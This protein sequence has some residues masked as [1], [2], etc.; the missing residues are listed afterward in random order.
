MHI[1]MYMYANI[2]SFMKVFEHQIFDENYRIIE[3][4]SIFKLL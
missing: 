1:H 2:Q 3:K 4:L